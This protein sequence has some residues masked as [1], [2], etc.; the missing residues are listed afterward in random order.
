M[1]MKYNSNS[2]S[3]TCVYKSK[4]TLYFVILFLVSISSFL[5]YSFLVPLN[6]GTISITILASPI[7]FALLFDFR[8][9]YIYENKITFLYP[10]RI[11]MLLSRRKEYALEEVDYIEFR[12]MTGSGQLH[13][14]IVQIKGAS[15]LKYNMFF[16]SRSVILSRNFN[17]NELVTKLKE[18]T[19][20]KI[21]LNTDRNT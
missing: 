13:Y 7:F 16:R 12:N 1:T 10:L 20:F 21:L 8:I 5:L 15:K 18:K 11:G 6:V 9:L 2:Q 19:A 14:L 3:T 4:P 17:R